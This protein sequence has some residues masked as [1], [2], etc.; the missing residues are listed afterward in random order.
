MIGCSGW[1]RLFKDSLKR[2][3]RRHNDEVTERPSPSTPVEA[4]GEVQHNYD[5]SVEDEV[6][7]TVEELEAAME[8]RD[9]VTK[10]RKVRSWLDG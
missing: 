1:G 8:S 2:L 3:L 10:R 4:E 7:Q 9:L 6:G 5:V